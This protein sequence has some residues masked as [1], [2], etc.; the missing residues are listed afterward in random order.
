MPTRSLNKL[1]QLSWDSLMSTEVAII[2]VN[3]NHQS[4]P[5]PTL[6]Y[7]RRQFSTIIVG[8]H[9]EPSSNSISILA[10]RL[11]SNTNMRTSA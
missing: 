8:Y 10:V 3:L 2:V 9:T 1:T 6:I 11:T 7:L 5:T 4:S